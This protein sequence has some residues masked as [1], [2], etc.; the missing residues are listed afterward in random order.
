MKK[1]VGLLGRVMKEL[2]GMVLDE[3]RVYGEKELLR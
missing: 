3:A 2:G 1:V